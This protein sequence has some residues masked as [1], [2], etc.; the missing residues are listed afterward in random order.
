MAYPGK[1]DT[2]A[3]ALAMLAGQTV[4]QLAVTFAAHERT[5]RRRIAE[6]RSQHGPEWPVK[7]PTPK[8]KRPALD[9]AAGRAR[10]LAA[11]YARPAPAREQ[12][13]AQDNP[14]RRLGPESTPD[15]IEARALEVLEDECQAED[16]S[17][18]RIAAARALVELADRR[19]LRRPPGAD[20]TTDP[21]EAAAAVM[22]EIERATSNVETQA[23]NSGAA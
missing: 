14:R 8:H 16:A 2:D 20:Q 21:A 15:E 23:A 12:A 18:A 19:R 7:R 13:P 11:R 1:I 5:V 3:L 6:E 17:T 4:E 22:L 9:P 10:A